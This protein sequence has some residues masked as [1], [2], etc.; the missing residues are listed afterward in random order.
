MLSILATH[1]P[2][3]TCKREKSSPGNQSSGW[4]MSTHL[5]VTWGQRLPHSLLSLTI[6]WT[7]RW[8][9][10]RP[11]ADS[12]DGNDLLCHYLNSS[13]IF[14]LAALRVSRGRRKPTKCPNCSA[15]A[16]W[17]KWWAS[18]TWSN[19]CTFLV[20]TSRI[21]SDVRCQTFDSGGLSALS[22]KQLVSHLWGEKVELWS[23][24]LCYWT[25][26]PHRGNDVESTSRAH[27]LES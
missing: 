6:E 11:C 9:S 3:A 25:S 8:L 5:P 14:S 21:S 4:Q 19:L 17:R 13:P 24:V 12:E 15:V 7:N 23:L 20:G 18:W 26:I 2:T 10:A 16:V 1:P 22:I 27:A